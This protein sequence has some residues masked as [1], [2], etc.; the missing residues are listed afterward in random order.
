MFGLEIEDVVGIM[1]SEL[2]VRV[3]G[4]LGVKIPYLWS[5]KQW[6]AREASMFTAF[7][8]IDALLVY[9]ELLR[10]LSAAAAHQTHIHCRCWPKV[11]VR[12]SLLLCM[13]LLVI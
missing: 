5:H 10:R 1:E 6:V 4:R 2:G 3:R 12:H 8:S 9:I 7:M 11:R 13:Q